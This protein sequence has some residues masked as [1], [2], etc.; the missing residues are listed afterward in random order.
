MNKHSKQM[1]FSGIT[2]AALALVAVGPQA[3]KADSVSGS[4]LAASSLNIK[5]TDKKQVVGLN[6]THDKSS[7]NNTVLINGK[8]LKKE[9]NHVLPKQT[10]KPKVATK[11][12]ESVD[13]WMPDKNLQRVV[14]YNLYSN[15]SATSRINK[16]DLSKLTTLQ[17]TGDY[18]RNNRDYYSAALNIESLE[19]LQYATNLEV[20]DLSPDIDSNINFFGTAYWHSHLQDISALKNL[21]KLTDV[22]MEMCS[23]YDISALS[24]KPNLRNLGISYNGVTDFSP[25]KTDTNLPTYVTAYYQTIVNPQIMVNKVRPYI[26]ATYNF[27]DIDGSNIPIR[28]ANDK[29][30]DYYVSNYLSNWKQNPGTVLTD[31]KTIEWDL[32]G[33]PSGYQGYMTVNYKG[34]FLGQSGYESGGWLIIPFKIY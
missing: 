11:A 23:I 6:Q 32:S 12:S 9:S 25:L 1:L 22:Y 29:N 4:T 16:Q 26:T 34:K 5:A 14:A 3:V 28:I 18:E 7:E 8:S 33:L 2:A 20:L 15:E 17:L 10:Q 24:N 31:G 19:G 21:N 27:K 13:S 30:K